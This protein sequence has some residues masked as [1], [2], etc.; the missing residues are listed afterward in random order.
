MILQQVVVE[1]IAS[2]V[3]D[4]EVFSDIDPSLMIN[5]ELSIKRGAVLL[6]AGTTCKDVTKIKE[7]A[8]MIGIEYDKPLIEQDKRF[9]D[10]LLYGYC[11]E[12]VHFVHKK[13][14]LQGYYMGSVGDIR[15]LRDSGTT[16]KGNITK[17]EQFTGKV[18]CPE[19][20]AKELQ[21]EVLSIKADGH[22]IVEISRLPVSKIL[23]S[24]K[25][26]STEI[27]ERELLNSS[28]VISNIES[29]LNLLAE[30]GREY[31]YK[32]GQTRNFT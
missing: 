26:L 30:T 22:S 2:F 27:N 7:L 31:L 4:L 13:K 9:T 5:Q 14:P 11:K 19:C 3:Q 1:R 12:P 17:I 6:W 21:P 15:Y 18:K 25:K 8:K 20:N 23:K 28:Q 32:Y 10:I 16:S 24:I 29:R